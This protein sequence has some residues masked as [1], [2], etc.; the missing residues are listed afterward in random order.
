MANFRKKNKLFLAIFIVFLVW[1]GCF[2]FGVLPIVVFDDIDKNDSPTECSSNSP[3]IDSTVNI[4]ENIKFNK[5]V[6]LLDLGD[7]DDCVHLPKDIPHR[8]VLVCT[9]TIFLNTLKRSSWHFMG[10]DVCTV[11]SKIL[12]FDDNHLVNAYH[13]LLSANQVSIQSCETGLI[14]AV[15]KDKLLSVFSGFKPYYGLVLQVK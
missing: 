6:L 1:Y 12:F 11:Q 3:Q 14:E 13:I 8:K 2:F 5:V 9:D 10:G 7:Y 15:Q 4:L